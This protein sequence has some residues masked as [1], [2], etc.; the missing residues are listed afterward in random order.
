MTET[1]TEIP[2]ETPPTEAPKQE[3]AAAPERRRRRGQSLFGPILLITIGIFLLLANLDRL[4]DLNWAAAL[5]LWPLLL[6]F[7]GLDIIVRIFP[8]PVGTIL[9]ALVAVVAVGFFAYVLLYGDR[10]AALDRLG[11]SWLGELK[12]EQVSYPAE[13]VTEA[14]INLDLSSFDTQV[15]ALSDSANLIEAD[16]VY[17]GDLTFDTQK[18]GEKA[19]VR[20]STQEGD[21]W[22]FWANPAN[23]FQP[24][25]EDEWQIGLNPDVETDLDLNLGS[26]NPTLDLEDLSLTDLVVNSGS[27]GADM[28]LPGG[29]YDMTFDSGSGSVEIVFPD[30]GRHAFRVQSGSGSVTMIIPA[31]MEVRL[32]V[33]DAGSGGLHLRRDDLTRI[34]RGQ[35]EDEGVWETAGY[36]DSRDRVELRLDTGSGSV[37]IEEG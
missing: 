30:S 10:I 5:Q 28:T 9:S 12:E 18:S 17:A 36:E 16:L 11:P 20:L 21:D 8:R 22:T 31:E 15:T 1:P 37:T 33:E 13:G 29:D 19:T 35:D 14:E 24:G 27:G 25:R 6:V 32:V 2:P 26:G 4:P 7:I 3:K 34:E 23:W